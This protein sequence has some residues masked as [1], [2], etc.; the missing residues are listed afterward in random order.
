MFFT[1]KDRKIAN[2]RAMI[3]NRDKLIM[4][5]QEQANALYE[6]NKDLRYENEELTEFRNK[7]IKTINNSG[8]I[9]DKY[10]KIN[11]LIS[12]YQSQN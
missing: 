3:E 6:E 11:E 12:D 4:D 1:R 2:Q 9:V 5:M 7:I 10:D 8:T